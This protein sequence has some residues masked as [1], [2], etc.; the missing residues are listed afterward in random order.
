MEKALVQQGRAN[1]LKELLLTLGVALNFGFIAMLNWSILV[2]ERR[3][4]PLRKVS[5]TSLAT[6][7]LPTLGVFVSGFTLGILD[8]NGFKWPS[9]LR[10]GLGLPLLIIGNF[11]VWSAVARIGTK[12]TSG[13]PAKLQTGGLYRFSRN[14]QY[15]AD[16][17]II[18]GW[19]VVSAS[20]WVLPVSI[21]AALAFL[22][23]P[24]AEEPWLHQAYGPAYEKYRQG[25][26]RFIDFKRL[27]NASTPI[28]NS[29]RD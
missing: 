13:G 20:V 15:V 25:T 5:M 28:T 27:L 12:A 7:W 19:T 10:W 18:L 21:G 24:L 11:T 29:F 14:P 8:W 16:L 2:P 17:A 4:W 23:A 9:A 26:A 22:L 3:I 6:V 1:P